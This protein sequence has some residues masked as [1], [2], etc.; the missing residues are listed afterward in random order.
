MPAKMAR[1][2]P[3]PPGGGSDAVSGYRDKYWPEIDGLRTIAVV[4][5]FAF[6]LDHRL[7]GGG[8]V[9]VDI[10]FVI[11]GYLIT[12]LLLKDFEGGES[13]LRFYQ[14]RVARI[15][16]AAF[17]V[18]VTTMIAGLFLYSSQDFA[19]VG[20]TG[21]AATL[22][23]INIKLL[24]QGNYF[25]ISPDAQPLI[26]YWSLAV[27]EQFYLVFPILLYCVIR[28]SR[29]LLIILLVCCAFSF[30][31]CVVVTPFAP[32][33]AFYLLPTRAWEL[34]AGSGLAIAKKQYPQR[35]E[36]QFWLALPLGL[37]FVFLSFVFVQNE[38]FPGWIAGLPVV[39]STLMLAGIDTPRGAIHRLLAHPIVVFV[40]KRSYSLYLW[41]WPTF[42]FVDYY[43]YLGNSTVRLVLKVVISLA[44]TVL[45][46]HFVERPTRL[47]LNVPRRR[48]T[49]FGAFAVGATLLGAAGYTI[50]SNYYLSAEPRNVATGGISVNSDGR[51]W[52]VLIGDSQG[53][54][55]GYE[56]ASLART[57]GFRLNVLSAAAGNELPGEPDTL[58]PSVLQ[59]LGDRKPD[60]IIVAQ[61]WSSKI[62]EDGE[63]H[64]ANAM[65][66][67]VTRASQ[68]IVLTQPPVPPPSATRQSIRAG[69][70][71]PFFEVPAAADSRLR[72]NTIIRKFE[73]DR[74]QVVDV[75]K[76]FFEVDNS[77]RLIAP[78]GRLT[79]QD[80]GHLSDSGTALVRPTLDQLLRDILNLPNE[81]SRRRRHSHS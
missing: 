76:Y 55:Y 58:W 45:T 14:R 23:F 12:G 6:H 77:I 21:L 51:G 16:P 3:L 32:T 39:G 35:F 59:F 17:L 10:F 66:A 34:L 50:R 40:G 2:A 68:I 48:V 37:I 62:G 27:E 46:Y 73:N 1:S 64:F 20:A 31:A 13:I 9:G 78:G 65:A 80:D 22:S 18:V 28:L 53:A 71:P 19:S 42:S 5:V 44:A 43:F 63:R 56:L 24:F 75:A 25:K 26:H 69:A 41:H 67:L 47:W 52:V 49:A 57:L 38:G 72:A 33:A 29:H 54:M 4:S 79:F 8:F 36:G 30:A 74:I 70:R 61:A 81:Y 15:A 11:S 7:L 60:V